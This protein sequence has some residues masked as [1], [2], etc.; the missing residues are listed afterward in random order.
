MPAKDGLMQEI[1]IAQERAPEWASLWNLVLVRR[2]AALGLLFSLEL[3]GITLF[4]DND[5]IAG[6]TGLIAFCH[7]WVR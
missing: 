5:Q 3:A 1:E 2:L 4:L 6:Q 7:D